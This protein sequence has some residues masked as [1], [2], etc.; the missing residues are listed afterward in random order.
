MPDSFKM[1]IANVY[2]LPAGLTVTGRI[3]SGKVTLGDELI[4][5]GA[6]GKHSVKVIA[7]QRFQE[8]LT[9]AKS[10]PEPVGLTLSGIERDLLRN[11]DSLISPMEK[12]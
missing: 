10:G 6:Q 2:S 8:S 4:L 9:S 7:I 1:I 11:R 12:A 5:D 3:E